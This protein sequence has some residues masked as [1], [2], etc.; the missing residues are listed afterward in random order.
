MS[1]LTHFNTTGLF[2]GGAY[3][4]VEAAKNI[5]NSD[6]PRITLIKSGCILVP[7]SAAIYFATSKVFENMGWKPNA[8]RS[9]TAC[10]LTFFVANAI[11]S[12]AAVG[13]GFTATLA[14]GVAISIIA[15]QLL[16]GLTAIIQGLQ[17]LSLCRAFKE[18]K[19]QPLVPEIKLENVSPRRT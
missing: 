15:L 5:V 9:V 6:I 14:T 1:G 16:F 8:F 7:L 2:L 19:M 3:F 12:A 13:F 4:L 11:S 10:V 18:K 17:N